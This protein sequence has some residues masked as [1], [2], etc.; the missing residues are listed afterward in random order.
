MSGIRDFAALTEFRTGAI[1][2][3]LEREIDRAVSSMGE[4]RLYTPAVAGSSPAPP[5]PS[6]SFFEM[7]W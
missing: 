6:G 7:G 5:I 3:G 4:L 2:D 1:Q